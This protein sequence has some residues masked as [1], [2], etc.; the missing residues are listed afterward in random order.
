MK[1][2][3]K[4]FFNATSFSVILFLLFQSC[5]LFYKFPDINNYKDFPYTTISHGNPPYLFEQGNSHIFDTLL[6][7]GDRTRDTVYVTLDEFLKTTKTAAFVVIRNDSILFENYYNGYERGQLMNVFSVSKSVTSLLVGLAV[8]DGYI[9]NVHDPVTNYIPELLDGD[10]RFQRLTIEH[11]LDM[12]S[13]IKFNETYA[14]RFSKMAKLFYGKDQLGQIKKMKFAHEPGTVYE[15]QSVST[16]IL[17]IALEKATGKEF[18]KYLEEKVWIPLGME[19][20]ATWSL[21]DEKHRSAKAY[22]GLNV[23]AIDLAKIGRLYLNDGNWNGKQIIN[24]EWVKRSKTPNVNNEGYQ[25]QW[26]S[27]AYW[28]TRDVEKLFSDTIRAKEIAERSGYKYYSYERYKGQWRII[29]YTDTFYAFGYLGQ[30]IQVNPEKNVIIIRIGN[31]KDC[32]ELF[33]DRLVRKL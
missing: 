33:M 32:E 21:D 10:E 6:V 20:D 15:Y 31:A 1:N 11:L 13:G 8:Q 16:A 5:A 14:T 18:G 4:A 19:F 28:H 7:K 12:R 9:K 26:Y 29:V 3:N 30:E 23:T 25:Y 27:K 2:R 17:G 24:Q 22:H